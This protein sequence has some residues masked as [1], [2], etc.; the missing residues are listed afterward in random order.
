MGNRGFLLGLG[1]HE[2]GFGA[3]GDLLLLLVV[4]FDDYVARL[5]WIADVKRQT[6]DVAVAVSQ[7]LHFRPSGQAAHQI[8]P[9]FH[10]PPGGDHDLHGNRLFGDGRFGFIRR[11]AGILVNAPAQ[12]E[13]RTHGE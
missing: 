5:N 1:D 12:A 2:S 13:R 3:G 8:R 9:V 7:N 6:G 10:R 11:L 4:Q